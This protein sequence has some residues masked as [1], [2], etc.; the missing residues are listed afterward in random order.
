MI[1]FS[2]KTVL[3]TGGSQGIGE[4]I[5]HIFAQAGATVLNFDIAA[6]TKEIAGVTFFKV[7]ITDH[8]EVEN[9][10]RDTTV[11]VLVNNAGIPGG[12]WSEWDSIIK[13]NLQGTHT[14][15]NA[16]VPTMKQKKSGAIIFITSVHSC[17][18]FSGNGPYDTVKAGL[19][20]YMR[21][22]ALELAPF[23]IRVNA[24]APGAIAHAGVNR[25]I[26]QELQSELSSRIPLARFGEPEEIGKAVAFLASDAAS[27]ITGVELAVDGGLL[28][29]NSL[30]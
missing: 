28:I 12:D 23:G 18:A 7:D 21:V 1:R 25:T 4:G 13:T 19:V 24:V 16:V 10:L 9:A 6:P 2:G 26:T 8:S 22:R 15:T 5:V 27:Y 11:D 17:V 20:G 14:V 30:I 3:V 29:K